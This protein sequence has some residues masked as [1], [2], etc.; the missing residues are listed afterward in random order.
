MDKTELKK[1][2]RDIPD[3]PK[4]GI[5]FKDISPVLASAKAR[6]SMTALLATNFMDKDIDVVV[7]MESRGFLFGLLLADVLEA[8]FVM[9]RKPGKL[10]GQLITQKYE[11][12]YG[13]DTIEMQADAIQPDDRILIHDDVLA[14]GGTAAAAQKLLQ[15][16]DGKVVG[17]SFMIELDFLKGRQH[18]IDIPVHSV[19]HY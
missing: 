3:F 7:G 14:T 17:A 10:P 2:I 11:L 8:A 5:L 1:L 13:H 12:E 4:P 15:A 19:L 6:K 18:L 9:L 16:T